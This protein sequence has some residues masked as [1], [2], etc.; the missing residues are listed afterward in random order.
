MRTVRLT[1]ALL[2]STTLAG[3]SALP[4]ADADVPAGVR[5]L[6]DPVA[7]AR[8]VCGPTPKHRTEA[9]KPGVQLAAAQAA[10]VAGPLRDEAPPLWDNL[11]GLSW[12]VTTRGEAAQ[13][14][15]DQGLR[16]AYGFNHGEARRAFRAAQAADPG[17][18]MCYWGEAW[19]WV[20]TST[21]RWRR[22]RGARVRGCGEGRGTGGAASPREQAVIRALARRYSPDPAADRKALDSPTPTA[23]PRPRGSSRR[24]ARSRS[25]SP[26]RS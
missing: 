12:T 23:W 15:F 19:V 18:A 13:P 11:G 17:C 5:E 10:A 25:S 3:A 26:T 1:L 6:L 22:R 9:F 24:R 4:A 2:A 16:L 7:V 8:S 14:Y 21:S 20:R